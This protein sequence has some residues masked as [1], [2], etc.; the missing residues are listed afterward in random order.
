MDRW[1]EQ[2]VAEHR[3]E[4]FR[5]GIRE[6]IREGMQEGIREGTASLTVRQ[7]VRKFGGIDAAV[8]ARVRKLPLGELERPGEELLDF[9]TESAFLEWLDRVGETEQ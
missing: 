6:G 1:T 2:L 3:L 8:E 7:L 9:Q 5:E 4:W